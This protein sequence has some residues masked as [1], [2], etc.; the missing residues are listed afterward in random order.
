MADFALLTAIDN[1]ERHKIIERFMVIND[2]ATIACEIPVWYW[3]KNINNGVTGH[4]DILQ[5][6]NNLV[7]ILDYKPNACKDKNALNQLYNYAV[8]LSF[9]ARVQLSKI[10]CAWFDEDTYYE[11]NPSEASMRFLKKKLEKKKV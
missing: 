6:R 4:I 5:V 11:Y 1:R 9:R 10:R 2:M 7:Y 8:A 3:D